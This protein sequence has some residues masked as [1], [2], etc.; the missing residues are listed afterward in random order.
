MADLKLFDTANGQV[1]E[2]P[3]GASQVE[4]TLQTLFENNLEVLL[5]VRFLA[6]EYSTGA[7]H[8][9]RIDTLGI[10]EDG[11]PV[12]I[13]YKRSISENVINQGLFYLDWL[14]DHQKEFQWLVMNKLGKDVADSVE[15]S[16]PRL[17]CIASDFTRYDEHAVKQI[18]RNIELLRYRRFERDLLALE[19]LHVPSSGKRPAPAPASP[20]LPADKPQ[21]DP[22]LYQRIDYRLDNASPELR[23]IWD[24]VA[25]FIVSLGDDIQV[26]ELKFYVAYKK[27]KNFVC[28]EIYPSARTVVAYLKIDPDTVQIEAGF[29][30]NVKKIGHFGTGDLEVVMRSPEDAIKAQP[31]L[32]RAYDEG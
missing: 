22:Y 29:T 31:L 11:T 5:G 27:I 15:W 24:S 18:A 12:I 25:E 14:M 20:G 17:L 9:G 6:T 10:D 4:K 2:L 7:T 30:R 32:Q 26:R 23:Q 13:E 21:G 8:G 19:L 28:M 1:T 16:G 3:P